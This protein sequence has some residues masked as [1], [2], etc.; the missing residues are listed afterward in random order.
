VRKQNKKKE[1]NFCARAGEKYIH[2]HNTVGKRK[3]Q[4]SRKK[5][6]NKEE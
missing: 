4:Y 3:N 2:T 1:N 6:K 5:K